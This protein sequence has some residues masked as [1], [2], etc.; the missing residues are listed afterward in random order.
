MSG[1]CLDMHWLC[2]RNEDLLSLSRY[3]IALLW[4]QK[5][6][7]KCCSEWFWN[8]SSS[9]LQCLSIDVLYTQLAFPFC[10]EKKKKKKILSQNVLWVF[11]WKKPVNTMYIYKRKKHIHTH[12]TQRS[13]SFISFFL[14]VVIAVVFSHTSG[15][16]NAVLFIYF[17][18]FCIVI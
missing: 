15:G 12:Y 4:W 8:R 17:T 13:A 14:F 6:K 2:K 16:M 3:H 5:G 10:N 9:L 7:F 1:L 11:T 18:L